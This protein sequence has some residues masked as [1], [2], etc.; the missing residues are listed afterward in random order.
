MFSFTLIFA[1]FAFFV[2]AA[3]FGLAYWIR[4]LK[5]ALMAAGI[6]F[7]AFALLFL[8]SVY[9]IANSMPN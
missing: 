5:T 8:G 7:A 2:L 1:G 9:I 6:V 4:G 3:V